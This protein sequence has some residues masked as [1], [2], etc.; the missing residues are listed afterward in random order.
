MKISEDKH[1]CKWCA[2]CEIF[3]ENNI[4]EQAICNIDIG[5]LVNISA[6]ACCEFD[7]DDTFIRC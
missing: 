7:Y 4:K 2:H 5:E 1:I 3:D 6:E